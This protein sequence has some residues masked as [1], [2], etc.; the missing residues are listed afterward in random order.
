MS[1]PFFYRKVL[2]SPSNVWLSKLGGDLVVKVIWLQRRFFFQNYHVSHRKKLHDL[3]IELEGA[4]NEIST[5]ACRIP[6]RAAPSAILQSGSLPSAIAKANKNF[7]VCCLVGVLKMLQ[8]HA[9]CSHLK[10]L[11]CIM[12]ACDAS[13]F[14]EVPKDIVKL[15]ARIMKKWW[16]SYGL[17]YMTETVH[18]ES[19][20]SS[21]VVLFLCYC[22]LFM[23]ML[24]RQD[25]GAGPHAGD[26]QPRLREDAEAARDARA[27]D[28]KYHASP[29]GEDPEV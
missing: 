14:N 1:L 28:E 20:V 19:E 3:R 29:E 4:M 25:D 27:Q 2:P 13:I 24:Q 6:R 9:Q 11:E 26:D 15:S 5:S 22:C 8:E 21:S 23:I 16:P 18:L 12:A 10:G 17:P 7:I